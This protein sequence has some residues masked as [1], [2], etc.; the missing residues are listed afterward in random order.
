MQNTIERYGIAIVAGS[1]VAVGLLFVM[2]S[3]FVSPHSSLSDVES[4]RS[5]HSVGLLDNP[6]TPVSD[7]VAQSS[8]N[9]G[10]LQSGFS[11]FDS[12]ANNSE[13]VDVA[14]DTNTTGQEETSVN[15]N[16]ATRIRADSPIYPARALERGIEGYVVLEFTLGETGSIIDPVVAESEPS[17]IFEQAALEALNNLRFRPRMVA[18]VPVATESIRHR[19][20][21]KI[22]D[23]NHTSPARVSGHPVPVRPLRWLRPTYPQRALQRGIE[24]HVVLEFTINE[25]GSVVDPA[26]VESEPLGIFDQSALDAASKLKYKPLVM[27]GKAMQRQGIKY[28]FVYELND[29]R[30]TDPLLHSENKSGDLPINDVAPS[31]PERALQRGIEGHVVLEVYG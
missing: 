21:F 31:Y 19:I 26:V 30:A 27:S 9:T 18:E 10:E 12:V 24:G 17:G 15:Q 20:D 11:Q 25:T 3:V 28:R 2:H 5:S 22:E 16:E 6:V 14:S 29:D 1:V 7:S 23:D 13:P 8:S 4:I